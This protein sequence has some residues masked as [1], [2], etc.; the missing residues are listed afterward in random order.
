VL[1]LNRWNPDPKAPGAGTHTY[2]I[3]V[4]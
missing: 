4:E 2:V 1:S 3:R